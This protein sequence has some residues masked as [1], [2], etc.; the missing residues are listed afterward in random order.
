MYLRKYKKVLT[1][2]PKG[3]LKLVPIMAL[4]VNT[5]FFNILATERANLVMKTNAQHIAL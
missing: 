4:R 2:V 3:I 1:S 5:L